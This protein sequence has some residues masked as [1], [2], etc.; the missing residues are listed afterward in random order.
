VV[1]LVFQMQQLQGDVLAAL[2]LAMDLQPV[3]LRMA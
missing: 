3:G 1:G 2:V